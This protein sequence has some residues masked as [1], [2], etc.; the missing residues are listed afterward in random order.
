M[1]SLSYL[2]RL[3]AKYIL[4]EQILAQLHVKFQHEC[5]FSLFP[6]ILFFSSFTVRILLLFSLYPSCIKQNLPHL[7]RLSLD[8][9]DLLWSNS[10]SISCVSRH[11]PLENV[12]INHIDDRQNSSEE[13]VVSGRGNYVTIANYYYYTLVCIYRL[14]LCIQTNI[15]C[16]L[17][18]S[19]IL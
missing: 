16:F 3:H 10:I 7:L 19:T 2:M 5:L 6:T 17:C 8:A 11:C 4:R 9:T 18:T 1:Q 13:K 15:Y 12:A 14:K